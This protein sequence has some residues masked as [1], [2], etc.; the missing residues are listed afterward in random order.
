MLI[1][2][3]L[4]D[5]SPAFILLFAGSVAIADAAEWIEMEH[6]CCAFLDIT[7]SLCGDGTTWVELGGSAAIKA[8]LKEECGAF[9][10]AVPEGG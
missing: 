1:A 8:F 9:R 6:R 10:T 7:L 4:E 2:Y 5:R 3:V